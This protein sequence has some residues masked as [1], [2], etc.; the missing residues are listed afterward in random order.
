MD[1]SVNQL[2]DELIQLSELK[3]AFSN[4]GSVEILG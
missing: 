3:K 2:D 1:V 4:D